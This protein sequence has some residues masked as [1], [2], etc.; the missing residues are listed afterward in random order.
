MSKLIPKPYFTLLVREDGGPWG[1]HFG[2]YDREVVEQER[3]DGLDYY[4]KRNMTIIK[5][6]ERQTEIDAAVTALNGGKA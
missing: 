1:I 3:I 6:G 4:H 2:D 5:T